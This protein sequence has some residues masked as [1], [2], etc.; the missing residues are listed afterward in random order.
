MRSSKSAGSLTDGECRPVPS[1]RSSSSGVAGRDSLS[2]GCDSV[3]FVLNGIS[4]DHRRIDAEGDEGAVRRATELAPLYLDT[5]LE[6]AKLFARIEETKAYVFHGAATLREFGLRLSIPSR[7]TDLLRNLGRALEL[8]SS[9]PSPPPAT[10]TTTPEPPPGESAAATEPPPPRPS[11]EEMVRSGEMPVENAGMLG[12]LHSTPEAVHEGEDWTGDA[13]K[14][15][16]KDFCRKVNNRLE[17]TRQREPVTPVVLHVIERARGNFA[18]AREVASDRAKTPLSEGETFALI[19]EHYLDSFAPERQAEG[20]RR[21]PDTVE[22]PWSRYVPAEV[23]REVRE[24]AGLQCEVPGC[25]CRMFLQFAHIRWHATGSAREVRDLLLV[26]TRHHT[27][28]DAGRIRFAGWE[29]GKP[30]FV[31]SN[32]EVLTDRGICTGTGA[33]APAPEDD[34]PLWERRDPTAGNVAERPPPAVRE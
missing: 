21:L 1:E 4:A 27:L 13:A 34:A 31:N 11:I 33:A 12:K 3:P 28:L 15:P 24:R 22:L 2:L 14:M 7:E 8:P 25:G 17:E 30:T 19:V 9:P 26:C 6:M 16:V 23:K 32:G 29:E 18:R 5:R 20:D 10:M